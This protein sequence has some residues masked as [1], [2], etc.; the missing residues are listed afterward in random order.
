MRRRRKER[1][2]RQKMLKEKRRPERT[3]KKWDLL[4]CWKTPEKQ[5][6]KNLLT[7]SLI[8]VLTFLTS[9]K[10]DEGEGEEL[11][12]FLFS[13]SPAFLARSRNTAAKEELLDESILGIEGEEGW[14]LDDLLIPAPPESDY[15][16]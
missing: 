12:L 10:D 2:M 14:I 6:L 16:Y 4:R 13:R 9:S 5:F 1:K 15:N 7:K 8:K 11:S 3:N